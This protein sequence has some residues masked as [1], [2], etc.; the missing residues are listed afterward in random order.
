M[1]S[2]FWRHPPKTA[3]MST[4]TFKLH[5]FRLKFFTKLYLNRTV[6]IQ[7]YNAESKLRYFF[8]TFVRN[9]T[10]TG[11]AYPK[12]DTVKMEHIKKLATWYSFNSNRLWKGST[13]IVLVLCAVADNYT[14]RQ[15]PL[16][17]PILQCQQILHFS[18]SPFAVKQDNHLISFMNY[19]FFSLIAI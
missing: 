19:S 5:R 8:G 1:A 13:R 6:R 16:H 2:I 3:K 11:F 4:N 9:V 17:A 7:N 18:W 10:S 12:W 15:A 14:W